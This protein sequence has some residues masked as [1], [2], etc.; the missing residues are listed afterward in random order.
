MKAF[1]STMMFVV[2]AGASAAA[3]GAIVNGAA[4][5]CDAPPATSCNIP[6]VG[7]GI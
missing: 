3:C 6:G 2:S 5:S 7:G 1:L 4:V